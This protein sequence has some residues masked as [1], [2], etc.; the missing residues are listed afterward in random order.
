MGRRVFAERN[1]NV[2][3]KVLPL[4][5]FRMFFD[6]DEGFS[7][8]EEHYPALIAR[9]EEHLEKEFPQLLASEFMMFKRNGNRS[10]YE[11]KRFPRR[12]AALD[13]A[14]AEYIERKGRFTDKLIDLL[15]LMLEE[16]TWVLPA[17]NPA[18]E[19]VNTCLPYAYEG[20]VDYIDLFSAT[21]GA[22][23]A[24]IYYICKDIL[25]EV[26]TIISDRILFE[27]NR[28]IIKPFM[29]DEHLYNKCWWSG[30][31]G[32]S[33]NNWCPWIVSNVLTVCA[34]TTES[35]ATR[36][37]LVK[38]ALNMLDNFTSVYHSDGGCDE[39]PSYWNA[40]GGA[41]FNA[42][43]VLYDMTGGYVN[44]FDDPL[45]KNMGE[46]IVKAVVTEKR[47]LTFADA[48]SRT[49][50]DPAL[51]YHWGVACGSEMMQN[52]AKYR[53]AGKLSRSVAD[54]N[55]VYRSLKFLTAKRLPIESFTPP[56]K[57]WLDGIIVAG[58]RE[59]DKLSEGLYVAMKGGNNNESHNHNDI[60]NVIVFSGNDPIFLDV[61][62]GQ[63][64]R[65][66]FS[67][68]RYE[69]WSMC[70]DYHNCATISGVTQKNGAEYTSKNEQYDEASGK[71][72]LDL[73]AAYPK[74][75]NIKAYTRSA[76]LENSTVTIED[77]IELS[78]AGD[79]AFSYIVN[80]APE[81]VLESSF[82]LY[83][84][85][86]SY[87]PSLEYTIEKLDHTEPETAGFPAAWDTEGLMRIS[88][89]SKEKI[90]GKK[91]VLTVK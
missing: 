67:S 70:S 40:A 90:T 25:D 1:F 68:H 18:K 46:Y 38:R 2:F 47:M 35:T 91:Y 85:T 20:D 79:V 80:K 41:L 88:L 19:G 43:L 5:D 17:H 29:T 45:I 73:S 77:I 22:T 6:T 84:R 48:P 57:I 64:T 27:L 86:V 16:T 51:V 11:K 87:D 76:V 8:N 60:G 30:V 54:S 36:T 65:K 50:P 58:T 66:T 7:I 44:V 24:F 13:L 39:G 23:L 72:T 63:Y 71:L 14:I 53:L 3:G 55:H 33:V 42:C 81:E 89:R 34:L 59:S 78:E 62:S 26:T 32:N 69:I 9:A 74:E 56:K 21:T 10:V 49:S 75:A 83:G 37:M 4:S 61:G 12:H 82:V 52:Y 15:W 31:R 28:R